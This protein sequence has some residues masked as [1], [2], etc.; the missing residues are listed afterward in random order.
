MSVYTVECRSKLFQQKYI[1]QLVSFIM[2]KIVVLTSL[3]N[4]LF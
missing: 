3:Q 1:D 4:I 2:Y